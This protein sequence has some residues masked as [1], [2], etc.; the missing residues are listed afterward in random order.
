M[1]INFSMLISEDWGKQGSYARTAIAAHFA[2]SKIL[3]A[4]ARSRRETTVLLT[5]DP[6]PHLPAR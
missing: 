4:C 3:D 2:E 5:S 1:M 6:P